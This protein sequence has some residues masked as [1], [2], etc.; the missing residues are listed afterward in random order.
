MHHW[1]ALGDPDVVHDEQ[2]VMTPARVEALAADLAATYPGRRLAG[3]ARV[4][5]RDDPRVQAAYLGGSATTMPE[6]NVRRVVSAVTRY[7]HDVHEHEDDSLPPP[8]EQR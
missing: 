6:D 4:D 3:F 8:G 7:D 5:S 1:S 2:S